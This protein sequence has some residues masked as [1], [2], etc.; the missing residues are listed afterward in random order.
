MLGNKKIFG[1]LRIWQILG[2]N[3]PIPQSLLVCI[4]FSYFFG[5]AFVSSVGYLSI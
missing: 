2:D 3:Y 1:K 4:S 5:I